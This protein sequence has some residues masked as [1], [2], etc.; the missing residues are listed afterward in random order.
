MKQSYFLAVLKL[1]VIFFNMTQSINNL[2]IS[3]QVLCVCDYKANVGNQAKQSFY[4]S[5]L[6]SL[7]CCKYAKSWL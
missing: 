2:I 6:T 4:L 1:F 3:V 5:T 7:Y